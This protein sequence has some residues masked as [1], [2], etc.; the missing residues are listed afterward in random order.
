MERISNIKKSWKFAQDMVLLL[1]NIS[2]VACLRS[3][4]TMGNVR[5]LRREII[6]Q[7]LE[8]IISW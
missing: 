5:R 2:R 3:I 8:G 4:C 1:Q 7:L 6:Y